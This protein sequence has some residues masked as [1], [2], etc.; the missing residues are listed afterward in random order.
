MDYVIIIVAFILL[1]SIQVFET[2]P[3][4]AIG[5]VETSDGAA[6]PHES[7]C[8]ISTQISPS[9]TSAMLFNFSSEDD[10]SLE[11]D[12]PVANVTRIVINITLQTTHSTIVHLEA[13]MGRYHSGHNIAI[14]TVPQTITLEPDMERVYFREN[15]WIS[16]CSIRVVPGTPIEFQNIVMWAEFETPLSPVV[17]DWESTD[18]EDLHDNSFMRWMM[19]YTPRLEIRRQGDAE[20]LNLEARFQNRVIYLEPMNYSIS[21]SW[22]GRIQSI[23]ELNLTISENVTTLCTFRMKAVQVN[24]SMNSEIPLI[25][26]TIT[27]NRYSYY[28]IYDLNLLGSEFPEYLFLPPSNNVFVSI[29]SIH[30]LNELDRIHGDIRIAEDVSIDGTFHQN[31]EVAMPYLNLLGFIVTPQD[32]IQISLSILLFSL[33]ILRM[34]LYLNSKKPR[35]SWNDPRLIPIVLIGLTSFLPWFSSSREAFLYFNT[36]IYVQSLGI[37]PLLACWTETGGVFLAIPSYGLSWAFVSL[38]LFWIPLLFA[39]NLTTPPS[40]LKENYLA[41]LFLFSPLLLFTFLQ[42]GVFSLGPSLFILSVLILAPSIFLGCIVLLRII[43][44]YDFGLL[45]NQLALDVKIADQL[46]KKVES[47]VVSESPKSYSDRDLPPTIELGKALNLVLVIIIF[48][49]SLIPTS[50]GF[51]YSQSESG[52]I[53]EHIY[54]INPVNCIGV[55]LNQI[56]GFPGASV[57]FIFLIPLYYIFTFGLMGEFAMDTRRLLS[58]VFFVIWVSIPFF[59]Y[60]SFSILNYYYPTVEW[61]LISFPYYALSC[62]AVVKAGMYIRKEISLSSLIIWIGI[63]VISIIPGGL[64]LNLLASLQTTA[65]LSTVY[66]WKPFPIGT[67][68]LIILIL[69]LRWL[70]QN[71]LRE[72]EADLEMDVMLH[73]DDVTDDIG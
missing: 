6:I 34:L 19:H 10:K 12:V 7:N 54:Y 13:D 43:G 22:N 50:I 70:Y 69:P 28:Q 16:H 11:I 38:I 5:Y 30:P 63:P 39:N 62:V 14:G 21:T 47:P 15:D 53:L 51:L 45:K 23:S 9:V 64:L 37:F 46:P 48:T 58:I 44:K 18:G 32:L 31:I 25:R 29:V 72:L 73:S 33:V 52:Y 26:L 59:V 42:D 66:F 49:L 35:V 68:F 71:K 8:T 1:A 61:I 56:V 55:I 17:L 20:A 4:R 40:D 65:L 57:V 3:L 60:T 24:F 27:D 67:I 41:P 2:T 36:T